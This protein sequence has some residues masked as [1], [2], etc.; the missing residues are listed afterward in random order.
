[1]TI[2]QRIARLDTDER[3][4]PIPWSVLRNDDGDP[5]FT[6]NDDRKTWQALC[7]GLCPLCGERLG[8]WKWFVGGPRS[9]FDAHGWYIDLPG[10]RECM[11]YALGTCPYLAAPRYLGR[12]DVVN[13][14]KLPPDATL[15]L[16]RTIISDRPEVFVATASAGMET[17]PRGGLLQPLVRPARPLVEWTF[18]RHGKQITLDE[19]LPVLRRVLG[20]EWEPPTEHGHGDPL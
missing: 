16:D 19:A 20:A 17:L 9:A 2:P 18:W 12:I 10:H 6:V 5:F 15:L 3:G 8:K 4:Y 14:E 13:P 7:E 1:M 11:E